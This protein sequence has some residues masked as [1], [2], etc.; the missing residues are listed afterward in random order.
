MKNRIRYVY[1]LLITGFIIPLFAIAEGSLYKGQALID[2]V[3][4]SRLV[5]AT[6]NAIELEDVVKC[7]L[8]SAVAFPAKDSTKKDLF[9]AIYYCVSSGGGYLEAV[10][11]E[12]TI[13]HPYGDYDK[14][15]VSVK[16]IEIY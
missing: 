10:N 13:E 12:G 9:S 4:R 16:K 2:A 15:E 3:Q 7:K 1:G 5:Q 6:T 8:Y 11:F 14:I